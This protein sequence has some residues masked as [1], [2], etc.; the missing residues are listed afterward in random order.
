MQESVLQQLTQIREER[1]NLIGLKTSLEKSGQD[2]DATI[3]VLHAQLAS[4]GAEISNQKTQV[5]TLQNDLRTAQK[6]ADVSER[7]Q[8]RLQTEGTNLMLSLDELRT[9]LVELTDDKIQLSENLAHQDRALRDQNSIIANLTTSLEE[10]KQETEGL[11]REWKDK[12]IKAEQKWSQAVT[13][14][15]EVEQ[16][17]SESQ[18]ELDNALN[19]TLVLEVER[20]SLR[21]DAQARLKEI[22]Q[23][24]NS[25]RSQAAE[26][27]KLRYELNERRAIQVK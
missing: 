4:A 25:S 10:A 19:N 18:K 24:S 14:S 17:L 11:R 20:Q 16:R 9:K 7:T 21:Q 6:R 27:T 5:H 12:L 22:E 3:T 2:K 1:D 15:S 26:I 13:S 8:Q 23:L